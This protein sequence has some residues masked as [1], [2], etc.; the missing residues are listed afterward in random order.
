MDYFTRALEHRASHLPVQQRPVR[1]CL[2]CSSCLSMF[3]N[4][5][6]RL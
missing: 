2:S 6:N 4:T 3:P 5:A 1:S